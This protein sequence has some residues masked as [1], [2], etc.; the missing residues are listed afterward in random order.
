VDAVVVDVT[1]QQVPRDPLAPLAG[2][3][4]L[5]QL[6]VVDLLGGERLQHLVDVLRLQVRHLP[7]GV[8]AGQH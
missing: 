2:R 5:A 3:D 8:L 6:V 1:G 4:G 7:E